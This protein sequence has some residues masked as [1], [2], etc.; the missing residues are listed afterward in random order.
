[1]IKL[2]TEILDGAEYSEIWAKN[3]LEDLQRYPAIDKNKNIRGLAWATLKR[4]RE[5]KRATKQKLYFA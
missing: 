1:M 5:E 4:I 2:T 3:I